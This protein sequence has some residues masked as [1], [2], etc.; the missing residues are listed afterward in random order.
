MLGL[1]C[2]KCISVLGWFLRRELGTEPLLN[3]VY[4]LCTNFSFLGFS[5]PRSVNKYCLLCVSV[6]VLCSPSCPHLYG[7]GG[8]NHLS[9]A[10]ATSSGLLWM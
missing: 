8:G 7:T 1:T 4:G 10:E 2:Y 5:A 6:W 3:P 9:V